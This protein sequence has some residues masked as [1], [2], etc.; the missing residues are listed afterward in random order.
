MNSQER[1]SILVMAGLLS[2]ERLPNTKRNYSPQVVAARL[3]SERP[4][5]F[6][7]PAKDINRYASPSDGDTF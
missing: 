1:Q 4:G 2:S 3:N 5:N 6:T 7:H